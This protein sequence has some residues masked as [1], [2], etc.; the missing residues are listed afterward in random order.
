MVGLVGLFLEQALVVRGLEQILGIARQADANHPALA[1]GV[2]VDDARIVGQ[3]L[4]HGDDFAG[5]RGA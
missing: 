4:V 2:L 5:D 1:V 3:L